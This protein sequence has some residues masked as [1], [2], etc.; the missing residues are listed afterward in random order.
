[1]TLMKLPEGYLDKELEKQLLP[2]DIDM[3]ERKLANN[4]YARKASEGIQRE[5]RG[6]SDGRTGKGDVT[7]PH[8]GKG[9]PRYD[10]DGVRILNKWNQ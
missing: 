6:R 7:K 1:M 5:G 9:D 10:A 8:G 3:L 2:E 4:Q